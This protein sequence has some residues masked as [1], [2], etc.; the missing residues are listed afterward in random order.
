MNLART[1]ARHAEDE[2]IRLF[3]QMSS[4]AEKRAKKDKREY[5]H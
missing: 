3:D 2:I 5:Q 1:K 4:D